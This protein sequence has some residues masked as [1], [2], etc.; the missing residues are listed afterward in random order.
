[1]AA[2]WRRGRGAAEG[3]DEVA[4]GVPMGYY[5]TFGAPEQKFVALAPEA[6]SGL[7]VTE[8]HLIEG[9]ASLFARR[10]GQ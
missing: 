2:C 8:G 7:T 5:S 10:P 4:T 9:Y 1:M 6:G 3:G